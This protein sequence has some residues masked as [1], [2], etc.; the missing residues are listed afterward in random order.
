MI[1]K[2]YSASVLPE[3]LDLFGQLIAQA[4]LAIWVAD[5]TGKVVLFN[6][7][8]K[9]LV[10]I[11]IPGKI[12]EH[13]NIFEDPIA[14][15]QGLV[16]YIKRVLNGE[17]IQTVVMLDTSVENFGNN[18]D[19]KVLYVRC[20]YFPVKDTVGN[21]EYIVLLVENIT[22]QYLDD[23]AVSKS[24]HEVERANI[25]MIEREKNMIVLKKKVADLKKRLSE[26]KS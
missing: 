16:P 11:E 23:I 1:P 25:E 24:S 2:L 14:T 10:G 19:P 5:R 9:N 4:P 18:K 7:A 13:Y 22:Q 15:A 20:L 3:P 21:F 8:M 26:L 17:V 12:L 6:E